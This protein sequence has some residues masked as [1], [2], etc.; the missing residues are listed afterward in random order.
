MSACLSSRPSVLYFFLF[1]A[2]STPGRFFSVFLRNF[3][4][5]SDGQIGIIL[6][7]PSILS[8]ASPVVVGMYADSRVDGKERSLIALIMASAFVFP[9][10]LLTHSLP[11]AL[12]FWYV[13]VVSALFRATRTPAMP[14]LDAY[15]LEYLGRGREGKD[16]E[17]QKSR[18]GE[19]R[20]WGAVGWGIS[21]ILIGFSLD[22]WGYAR[23]LFPANF[24][25]S[26][27]FAALVARALYSR[28][29]P[30]EY[31]AVAGSEGAH[32][33]LLGKENMRSRNEDPEY[34]ESVT[35]SS[36][37][38]LSPSEDDA[39]EDSSIPASDSR[40]TTRDKDMRT[41]VAAFAAHVVSNPRSLIFLLTCA[42]VNCGTV[43]TEGLVFLYFADMNATNALMGL[44]V[45]VTV[46]FEIPLLY[47]SK[48]LASTWS[49]P[50]LMLGGM[51]AYLIRVVGYT[52]VTKSEQVLFFEPLHGVT[53]ALIQLA[54]VQEMSRLAP[55]HLQTTGQSFLS[56]AKSFGAVVGTVG[57]GY[58]MEH[59][60]AKAAYRCMAGL[61]AVAGVVYTLSSFPATGTEEPRPRVVLD[62]EHG[63]EDSPA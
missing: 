58:L 24:V 63:V 49:A 51:V 21:S 46:M 11:Q 14:T 43:L 15:T 8:M 7:V 47:V 61:V 45:S 41:G 30:G 60:G 36:P 59:Y 54:S 44:T 35:R 18:Y 5:L 29:N 3:A 37:E 31:A 10:L 13:L 27:V 53:Y 4:G 2:A 25:F 22:R 26:C 12:Q 32:A 16:A 62:D 6:G 55:P 40:G 52:L 19:E 1:A 23:T 57:G 20:V 34:E 28:G 38:S 39:A 56:N 42:C 17:V 33:R 9:L 48:R 50:M